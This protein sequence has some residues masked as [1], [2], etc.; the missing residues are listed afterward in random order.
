MG[1]LAQEV[2]GPAPAASST[3]SFAKL[4]NR[5]ARTA[6]SG[7]PFSSQ[8]TC[9]ALANE[10]NGDVSPVDQTYPRNPEAR[11]PMSRA[12][13]HDHHNWAGR[14]TR[15]GTTGMESDEWVL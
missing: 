5:D 14:R 3:R 11:I 6:Y 13:S 1:R 12:E 9:F 10:R 15:L 8:E 7:R 2:V 4:A